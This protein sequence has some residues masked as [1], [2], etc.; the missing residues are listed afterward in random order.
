MIKK[1]KEISFVFLIYIFFLFVL[2]SLNCDFGANFLIS[3]CT[4][5]CSLGIFFE[6]YKR[7]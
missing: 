7:K 6:D 1:I 3:A 4:V 5:I 2:D